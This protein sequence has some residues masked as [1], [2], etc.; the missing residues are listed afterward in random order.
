[1][2]SWLPHIVTL[3]GWMAMDALSGDMMYQVKAPGIQSTWIQMVYHFGLPILTVGIFTN[4]TS[5][6]ELSKWVM[7]MGKVQI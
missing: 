3:K 5:K 6:L 2:A 1:M 7:K 4:S